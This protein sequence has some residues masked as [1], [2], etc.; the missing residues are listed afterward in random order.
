[1]EPVDWVD[2]RYGRG[3]SVFLPKLDCTLPEDQSYLLDL[4]KFFVE[5]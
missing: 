3:A 1:M 5:E 4:F 2:G